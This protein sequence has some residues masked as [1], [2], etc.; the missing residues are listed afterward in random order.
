VR[1]GNRFGLVFLPLPV[2]LE[3]PLD[4]LYELKQRMDDIKKSPEA[5]VA[6]GLLGAI[7][8]APTEIE[9]LV[10]NLFG[11]RGTAVMTNVPGPREPISLAGKRVSGVMFW[12]PQSGRL[13]L[14]LSLLSCAN[15]SSGVATDAGL[16][17]DPELV[18]D[19]AL[20]FGAAGVREELRR[21]PRR[22]PLP[23]APYLESRKAVRKP[24]RIRKA[25]LGERDYPPACP[26]T[27]SS[28][29]PTAARAS[30]FSSNPISRVSS[31]RTA[32]SAAI[33]GLC[34]CPGR[35]KTGASTSP[36]PTAPSNPLRPLGT[37]FPSLNPLHRPEGVLHSA[38]VQNVYSGPAT[39]GTG[40]AAPWV[41]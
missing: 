37:F 30:R 31:F 15:V 22:P 1:L 35:T 10:L 24:R 38:D 14:G 26:R 9:H 33:P 19:F 8:M 16:V 25:V 36:G 13:G 17:P 32:R 12:V 28:P 40:V 11:T 3:D 41:G 20:E 23:A 27:F 39:S 34:A 4:R 2:G 18:A 5:V 6:F 29:A 21:R 7:G